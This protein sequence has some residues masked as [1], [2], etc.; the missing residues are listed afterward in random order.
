MITTLARTHSTTAKPVL[1]VLSN[2]R[3]KFVFKT[4]YRLMHVNRIAECWSIL[5]YVRPSLSYHLSLRHLL[6]L[7]LS[8]RLRQGLLCLN[9]GL[10]CMTKQIHEQ[11]KRTAPT[12]DT[13][14]SSI[15]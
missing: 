2:I 10:T 13:I 9:T 15:G 12:A 5:Q 1:S 7:V 6:C 3:L 4:D 14:T 11:Q 8:G